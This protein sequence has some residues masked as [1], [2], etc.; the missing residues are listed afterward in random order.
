MSFPKYGEYKESGIQWLG[1]IPKHWDVKE[2]KYICSNQP[3]NV[4]KKTV[5]GQKSVALCN[6]TDVY[7][8][9]KIT[10]DM[11][12]MKASA[13]D[14]QIEKFTLR[15]GDVIITKDSESA[16]DIAVPTYVPNDLPD[17]VCGYHLAMIRP[18]KGVSGLFIKRIFD[19]VY[20]RSRVATLA[21]GLTRMGL[22]HSDVSGL[23]IPVPPPDEQTAIANF[24]DTETAKIDA[25]VAEQRRLIELLKEKRQAVISHAV[26]KGLNPNA[27]MKDS[28]IEWLGDVPEHWEVKAFQ[29]CV[30]VAEGQVDP[31]EPEYAKMFLIAPNHIESGTGQLHDLETAE[32]QAAISGKYFCDSGDVIYS[33]IRPALRK[34]C[35]APEDCLC[36]A[37]MYPL[38]AHSGLTNEFL[39]RWI[40]TE[41]FSAFAVL[42]SDRVAMPKIN[43]ESLKQV[44]FV[45]PP[46]AEQTEIC[47]YIT[48]QIEGFDSLVSE[49]EQAIELLQERRTALISA[50][51]TGKIDV[52]EYAA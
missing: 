39:F 44:K 15:A 21:N 43:R 50:A 30:T 14:E 1:D 34:V 46:I 41:Q 33:K 35:V 2:L 16:D 8:N 29:R 42:E 26:T 36:S 3:S 22:S 11:P 20:I 10:A 49:A 51:V 37:D 27:P 6:Y 45:L 48:K 28:G 7:Y 47:H 19:S 4:D 9:E 17:V 38:K 13:T 5:E 40:L 32:E 52:R 12:F 25:L 24:L 31:K 23:E 18:N